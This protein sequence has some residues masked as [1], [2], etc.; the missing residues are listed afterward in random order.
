MVIHRGVVAWMAVWAE[1]ESAPCDAAAARVE[2]VAASE[3]V[4][5]LASLAMGAME[6]ETHVRTGRTT[7]DR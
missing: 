2:P 4:L 6:G 3:L 5:A 7:G 1:L